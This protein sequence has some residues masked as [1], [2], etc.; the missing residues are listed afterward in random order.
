MSELRVGVVG[1]GWV[2]GARYVPV[3]R[4]LSEI[5]VVGIA[6]R[7]PDRANTLAQ[8]CNARAFGTVG[9]LL[10]AGLDAA[11]ICT[12]PFS[13][14]DLARS[15]ISR[16]IHVLTEKPMAMNPVECREMVAAAKAAGVKLGVSHNFLFSRSMQRALL[17]LREGALGELEYVTAFQASS[18]LRRLPHWYPQLPGGLFFDESPHMLYL[19]EA[20][21]EGLEL[22]DLRATKGSSNG[23][24]EELERLDARFVDSRG[25]TGN[26][27][28]LFQA[29]VSEWLVVAVG[30]RAVVTVDVFRDIAVMIPSDGPHRPSD[31]LRTSRRAVL[32]HLR[33][34]VSSGLRYAIGRQFWGHDVLIRSFLAAVRD[35]HQPSVTGEDGTRI[36]DI[37]NQILDMAMPGHTHGDTY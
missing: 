34:V 23:P 13:H 18:P 26:L 16:G 2:A 8:T 6:D 19:M 24:S 11:F 29:P 25:A 15:A 32:G 22:D 27:T 12:S 14:A 9:E 3:L 5:D 4:R 31:I 36:V 17:L 21:M 10:D 30:T 35:G 37:M 20:F 1:A 33:G 28:M 7:H